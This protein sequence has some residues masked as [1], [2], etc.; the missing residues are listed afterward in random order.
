MY[1]SIAG[2][3]RYVKWIFVFSTRYP[4]TSTYACPLLGVDWYYVLRRGFYA[5]SYTVPEPYTVNHLHTLS[6]LSIRWV[7]RFTVVWDGRRVC[8]SGRLRRQFY[9]MLFYLFCFYN[10]VP[11]AVGRRRKCHVSSA[12]V[13]H[14]SKSQFTCSAKLRKSLSGP[15]SVL[16]HCRSRVLDFCKLHQPASKLLIVLWSLTGIRV[17][18]S[19]F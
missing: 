2:G 3:G 7:R 15:Y 9:V 13:V 17:S 5:S 16:V 11:S 6:L 14:L 8:R 4:V 1:I 19:C 10:A 18:F 12:N